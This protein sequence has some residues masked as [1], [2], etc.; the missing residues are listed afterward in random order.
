MFLRFLNFSPRV[1]P[2]LTANCFSIFMKITQVQ[3]CILWKTTPVANPLHKPAHTLKHSQTPQCPRFIHLPTFPSPS[4]PTP[5]SRQHRAS[6]SP[7]HNQAKPSKIVSHEQKGVPTAAKNSGITPPSAHER[8]KL[9]RIASREQKRVSIEVENDE[10][11]HPFAHR[12][13]KSNEIATREQEAAQTGQPETATL[14]GKSNP[15]GV[16]TVTKVGNP[17][18]NLSRADWTKPKPA[19]NS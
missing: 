4:N 2:I 1:M 6:T 14:S 13:A 10:N 18:R 11:M 12:R 5:I 8:A 3:P 17:S 19:Q 7:A 15:N 16:A 9:T